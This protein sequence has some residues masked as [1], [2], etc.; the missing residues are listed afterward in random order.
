[1][2]EYDMIFKRK[3][4][5][6]FDLNKHITELELKEI[7]NK[8]TTLVPLFN[9]I[10]VYFKIVKTEEINCKRGEYAVLAY[11]QTKENYLINI[12]YMLEQLDLYF[13]LNDIGSCYYGFGKVDET[14]IDDK[15]FVIMIVFGK[16]NKEDFRK[17]YTKAKRKDTT[18]IW[19]G[20]LEKIGDIVKY[21]PSACNSQPWLVK[22]NNNNIDIYRNLN[23][24]TLSNLFVKLTN[25]YNII[26][27]GIFLYILEITLKHFNY[28]FECTIK[29]GKENNKLIS[30]ANYKISNT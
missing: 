21:A 7:N 23:V 1:M 29:I 15:E 20:D 24:N 6:N 16:C 4:Q 30:I 22:C 10:N 28:K 25:F 18:N 5:R 19:Q 12:G 8:I 3:S 13:A 9:N 14:K 11:S 17:D 26:D 2:N 27:I